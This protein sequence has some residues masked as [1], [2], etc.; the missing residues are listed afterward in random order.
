[1]G[2]NDTREVG[3]RDLPGKRHCYAAKAAQY[4]S[5]CRPGPVTAHGVPGLS[6]IGLRKGPLLSSRLSIVVVVHSEQGFVRSCLTSVLRHAP[7]DVEVVVIDDAAV[8][9][10][11]E[12]AR[13]VAGN[14]SRVRMLH[15]TSRHGPGP[16]R[17]A[18]LEVTTGD[19]VWFVEPTDLLADDAVVAVLDRLA[20]S[21]P[22]D[23][24]V[25]GHTVRDVFGS[26]RAGRSAT[27]GY[28][29]PLWDKV[30]R[31]EVIRHLDLVIGNSAGWEVQITWPVLRAARRVVV[32][33]KATYLRR[34]LPRAVR[35]R[36]EVGSPVEIV[37]AYE[38]ALEDVDDVHRP[39]LLRALADDVTRL[40]RQ[41]PGGRGQ[42]VFDRFALSWGH[43]QAD[44]TAVAGID[45]AHRRA[46]DNRSYQAWRKAD[47]GGGV[48]QRLRRLKR[49]V[50]RTARHPRRQAR[51]LRSLPVGLW[52]R[53]QQRAPLD[54]RL[55]V[56]AAYWYSAYSC[57]PRAIYEKARELAPWLRGVWVVKADVV[58]DLPDGVDHVV[59]GT[60]DYYRLMARAT[61]FVNNVNFPNDVV[62][63]ANQV[64]V[65]THHG[66][67]LKTMGMDQ[68][69]SPSSTRRM[70]FPL[71]LKRVARWDYSI[72]QNAFSSEYWERVYPSGSYQSLETGY[73]RNDVL[74]NA[75]PS[76][77]AQVR[78]ELNLQE[79]KTTVL[80]AP[81][82]REY[83]PGF[84]PQLDPHGLAEALGPD[85]TLLM[86]AHYFYRDQGQAR[87]SGGTPRS[88]RVVDVSGHPRIED[89]YLAADVLVT[90][91]SSAMF[92][93]AV[94]DRPIV[95][96]GPDWEEYRDRRGTT[97]DLMAE[98]PGPV[99]LSEGDLTEFLRTGRP[100]DDASNA[101]RQAFR[102]RFCSLEDGKA[103]D[104][105]VRTLWPVE[106]GGHA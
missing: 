74:A 20:A 99:A 82:H 64:H 41:F 38:Q 90:D 39:A 89:L 37:Q 93:F 92:D 54:D 62:K 9:H 65:Q 13:E 104:R 18:A 57:N 85:F 26:E 48:V 78:A 75:T 51:R 47:S 80:Y 6:R 24:L 70:N 56:Y 3:R 81:T 88:G 4:D 79:G 50:T 95:I 69:G 66:T 45:D 34:E 30:I 27:D 28:T 44:L 97:F 31:S 12:I 83:Q 21:E 42:A 14:D 106:P 71:L 87:A 98:P 10:S 36:A 29:R 16:A 63:R 61:Y 35:A 67:P 25:V 43:Y 77:V 7:E 100:W 101:Q 73:P 23:V 1:M 68:V 102:D 11:G 59:A 15:L 52:Y 46:L 60:R 55:V 84:V 91:Y 76:D 33:D 5:A 72:S 86:R 96:Y 19:Y 94:L 53:A 103:S 58:K 17:M 32:L 105:V 49:A 40:L 8:D 2:G 22:A